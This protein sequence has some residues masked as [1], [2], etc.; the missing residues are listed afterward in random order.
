[1]NE[2]K[3]LV[4][5]Y[6]R[7]TTDSPSDQLKINE[8]QKNIL[9]TKSSR[10]TRILLAM[11]LNFLIGNVVHSTSTLTYFIF[12]SRS[13]VY[14]IYSTTGVVFSS[15]SRLANVVIY[16]N[17]SSVFQKYFRKIFRLN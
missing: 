7:P 16:Y 1:M 8:N 17:M 2:K 6:S 11:S 5:V 4:L 13:Q 14:Q 9:E 15:A 3:K 10:V 12:G